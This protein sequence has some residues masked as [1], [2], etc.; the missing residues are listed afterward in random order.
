MA[1]MVTFNSDYLV[2]LRQLINHHYR[3]E[4]L[5]SLC[6]DLGLDYDRLPGDTKLLKV[7]TLLKQYDRKGQLSDLII[8]LRNK[9]PEVPWP[10]T[11]IMKQPHGYSKRNGSKREPRSVLQYHLDKLKRQLMSKDL[12]PSQP[13]SAEREQARVMTLKTLLRLDR[14]RKRELVQFLWKSGL[15]NGDEPVINLSGA[16][17]SKIDLSWTNLTQANLQNVNLERADLS[18]ANFQEANLSGANLRGTLARAQFLGADLVKADLR[19]SNLAGARLTK[20]NLAGAALRL[21]DLS[22]ALLDHANL[23]GADLRLANMRAANLSNAYLPWA[24]MRL[25]NLRD[26][27]LDG[28]DLNSVDL[29]G[30]EVFSEQ[31]K[32]VA[33]L[34]NTKLPRNRRFNYRLPGQPSE[35][36]AAIGQTTP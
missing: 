26:A 11:P 13:G 31:L 28:A 17:L 32:N 8:S 7:N 27:V 18:L 1:Q 29:R 24:N 10:E 9:N 3:S 33:N 25:V 34:N 36:S 6:T 35:N 21:A 5:R 30:S 19:E 4:D 14:H 15:I 20:A 22:E 2:G 16:N 23:V 12:L